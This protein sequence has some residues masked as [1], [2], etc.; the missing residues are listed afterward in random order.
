M[1]LP[2]LLLV[3]AAAHATFLPAFPPSTG[4]EPV[5]GNWSNPVL[6]ADNSTWEHS[7]V[8]VRTLIPACLTGHGAQQQQ[9]HAQSPMSVCP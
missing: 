8:Q 2:L 1:L 3:P 7:A 4:W 6:V 5:L 9:S